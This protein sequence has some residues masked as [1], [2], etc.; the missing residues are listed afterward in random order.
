MKKSLCID[1]RMWFSSGIG[2]YLRHL[3]PYIV[4]MFDGGVSLLIKETE[5]KAFSSFSNIKTICVN[6]EPYSLEEQLILPLKVP[7]CDLFWSPHYTVPLFPIRAR[8]RAVTI[9]DVC[10]IAQKEQLSKLKS[11][12]AHFLIS[13]A[14]RKSNLV[15]TVSSFSQKEISKYFPKK[16]EVHVVSCAAPFTC[17]EKIPDLKTLGIDKPFILYVG[18]IK[19]HKNILGLLKAVQDR[20]IQLVLAGEIS[21][22]LPKLG[23]NVTIKEGL[24]NKAL[25]TLYSH[26]ELLIQPSLYEGFGL[27][28]FEAMSYECPVVASNIPSLLEVCSEA[29]TYVDPMSTSSI[30][31]G[32]ERV[33]EDR[34]LKQSLIHKGRERIKQFSWESSAQKIV[35]L[36]LKEISL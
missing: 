28:P 33:L 29:A 27:T 36:F 11:K 25:A 6:A 1:A 4:K 32:I 14:L 12:G 18:N 17:L 8:K 5:A 13:E 26:A 2:T 31:L 22:A 23:P 15:L 34:Q 3:V 24:S 10:H 9:H 21:M 35:D 30:W 19:S 16:K 7:Y 20:D